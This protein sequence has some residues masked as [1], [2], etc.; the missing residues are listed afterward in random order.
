MGLQTEPQYAKCNCKEPLRTSVA[1]LAKKFKSGM[2]YAG[3]LPSS[4]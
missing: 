1:Q 2:E 3:L 4:Q